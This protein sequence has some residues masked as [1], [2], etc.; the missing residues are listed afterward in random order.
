MTRLLRL[1]AEKEET[2]WIE[3]H[4]LCSAFEGAEQHS[5]DTLALEKTSRVKS[6]WPVLQRRVAAS[7]T[8]HDSHSSAGFGSL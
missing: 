5:G 8:A 6:R 3:A 2:L 7:T 4:K 1:Y